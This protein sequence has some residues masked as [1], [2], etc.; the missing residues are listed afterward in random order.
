MWTFPWFV[1][2]TPSSSD[3]TDQFYGGPGDD[4]VE[5]GLDDIVEP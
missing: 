5:A 2:D 4:S 1:D 3:G